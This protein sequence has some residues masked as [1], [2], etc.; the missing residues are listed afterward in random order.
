MKRFIV[1][2]GLPKCGTTFLQQRVFPLMSNYVYHTKGSALA[3]YI[4]GECSSF[5][6]MEE[7]VF[8]SDESISG[9]MLLRHE[10]VIER[11][12]R[13]VTIE[14]DIDI[15]VVYFRRELIE[16]LSS[17]YSEWLLWGQIAIS[18][19]EF[20]IKAQN[21][22]FEKNIFNLDMYDYNNFANKLIYKFP[23]I[24][25][26]VY[27]YSDFRNNNEKF[28]K[29]LDTDFD[30]GLNGEIDYRPVRQSIKG[31]GKIYLR[32]INKL[33]RGRFNSGIITSKYFIY[34]NYHIARIL[35]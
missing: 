7:A 21:G 20:L 3:N 6:L 22:S 29:K 25:F 9:E 28:I 34:A 10:D 23:N 33:I 13:I 2:I 1:H 15:T 17:L 31:S 35:G 8:V 11:I 18:E 26:K 12:N 32:F 19:K 5:D 27:Q 14:N 30:L 16:F 4:K 24:K